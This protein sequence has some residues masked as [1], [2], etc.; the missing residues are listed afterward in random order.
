MLISHFYALYLKFVRSKLPTPNSPCFVAYTADLNP[1]PLLVCE[2]E[3]FKGRCR[4][5]IKLRTRDSLS[6]EKASED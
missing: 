3:G 2:D 5:W 6:R 4:Q 1:R